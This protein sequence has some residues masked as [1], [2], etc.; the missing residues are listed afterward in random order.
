MTS[1]RLLEGNI[2]WIL[3]TCGVLL[4][5]SVTSVTKADPDLWGH[6]RFGLD[7]LRSG[8]LPWAD[9]YSFTQ[10]VPWIN[11]EW[12]SE[13]QM[14]LAWTVGGTVGLTIL[15]GTLVLAAFWLVWSGLRGVDFGVRIVLMA[16]LALGAARMIQT[17]RPQLWSLLALTLLCRALL[18]E[19][20]RAVRWLP[21]L[22][23]LWANVHGGWVVGLGM[24]GAWGGV[25][26]WL[27]PRRR[28]ELLLLLAV[29]GAGTLVTPYGWRLWAFIAGTVRMT[30]DISEWQPLWTV[31]PI[32]WGPWLLAFALT[33]WLGVRRDIAGLSAAAALALLAY[34]SIRVERITPLFV[35]SAVLLSAPRLREQWP[36][37]RLTLPPLAGR[38]M[39]AGA[40]VAAV[41]ALTAI[42]LGQRAWSCIDVSGAWTPDPGIGRRLDYAQPGRLVVFFDWGQYALWHWGPGLKVSMDGRRETVYSDARLAEH[43]DVLHGRP[44][45]LRALEGWQAEYVWLPAT[46][47][48]TAVW[49]ADNG[50]RIEAR[51]ERSFL[52][53]RSDLPV[54]P[55]GETDAGGRRCFPL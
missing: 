29:C 24:L 27:E 52:A 11:H 21:L 44:A 4:A 6:V 45:G 12:L 13:I 46:S 47:E 51:G 35:A 38:R 30:R 16:A 32:I 10:D 3:W 39:T 9:P 41:V 23:V 53:V 1:N 42:V 25:R 48:A 7:I 22:F 40:G 20:P 50:Y 19:R 37:R 49:L 17:L 15:K 5:L 31:H 26:W 54:L 34:A 43:A 55:R 8:R 33:V 36:L 28:L 18:S 2:V 14:G